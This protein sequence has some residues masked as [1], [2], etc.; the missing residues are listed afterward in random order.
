MGRIVMV[1]NRTDTQFEFKFDGACQY[2]P[3]GPEPI[4]ME[5]AIAWHGFLKSAFAVDK[6]ANTG[7]FKLGIV[8]VHETEMFEDNTGQDSYLDHS[9][10]ADVEGTKLVDK[11]ITNRLEFTREPVQFVGSAGYG[12]K[13]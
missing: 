11:P 8:G 10:I 7:K 13:E 4:P 3:P 5:E 6:Y 12:G 2:V 9:V 1:V